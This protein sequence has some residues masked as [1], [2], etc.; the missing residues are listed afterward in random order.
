[1]T[2]IGAA[3]LA[4]VG[5]GLSMAGGAQA[6]PGATKAWDGWCDD[7]EV[8]FYYNSNIAGA[9]YDTPY[10]ASIYSTQVFVCSKQAHG[11]GALCSG[12]GDPVHNNA[13]S[14]INNNR[15]CDVAVY[16]NSN[17]TG[18]KQIIPRGTWANLNATLKNQNAS[19]KFINC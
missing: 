9:V 18:P 11:D 19:H 4:L 5:A 7:G 10:S 15:Y 8:C 6:A 12:S 13:A 17:W 1:M 3:A 16:Y 14:V 2:A